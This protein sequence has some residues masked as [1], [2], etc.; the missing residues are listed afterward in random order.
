M[1]FQDSLKNVLGSFGNKRGALRLL[2]L[3][4][5]HIFLLVIS[6]V[7]VAMRWPGTVY[8][9]P[10]LMF[11]AVTG[12]CITTILTA[13]LFVL[14]EFSF[15]YFVGYYLYSAVIGFVWLSYSSP[16]SYSHQLARI[17][18]VLSLITFLL[19]GLWLRPKF[20]NG[21]SMPPLTFDLLAKC[22]LI[23]CFLVALVAYSYGFAIVGIVDASSARETLV[24]PKILNY[25][26][27]NVTGACLP[28]LFA[29][30]VSRRRWYLVGIAIS[31]FILF[32]PVTLSRIVLLMPAFLIMFC[33]LLRFFD[34]RSVVVLSLLIPATI[35]M[36]LFVIFGER[37][38]LPFGVIN[39]RLLA[40]PASA[41]NYY[42]DF[43]SA[44]RL[45]YFCQISVVDAFLKCGY[46]KQLSL[47]MED[48][49]HLG[50]FNASLLATEG[51]A[52]VGIYFAPIA[53]FFC[54]L[55]VALGSGLS[56]RLSDEFVML[57]SAVLVISLL[58]VPLSVALIT[59]GGFLLFL[60]WLVT[61]NECE[62]KAGVA[63]SM[64]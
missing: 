20:S 31:L 27:G 22:I 33:V 57:S 56:R 18:A 23:G 1:V 39:L 60:L 8:Y 37:A 24:Y 48:A 28:F 5:A 44:H 61:P 46:P 58:N 3:I 41:L 62:F 52:S 11:A 26:I 34:A 10:D 2:G 25:I 16:L 14:M 21:L 45:T 17:S 4:L 38:L 12:V 53:T 32:Y 30:Y 36:L 9:N 63:M 35:G 40:I 47:M 55:V 59:N 42:N 7:L 64:R 6:L 51:I 29:Y 50:N 54:G 49:Y 19:P 15:L 43:F 13:G